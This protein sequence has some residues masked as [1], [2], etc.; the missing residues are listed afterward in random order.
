MRNAARRGFLDQ[1]KTFGMRFDTFAALVTEDAYKKQAVEH[2]L[3]T[4][5][6]GDADGMKGLIP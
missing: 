5:F 1:Q 6:Q 4:L 3:A 2:M